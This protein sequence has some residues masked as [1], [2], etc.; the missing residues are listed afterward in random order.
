MSKADIE[1]CFKMI[2]LEQEK[3]IKFS[4]NKPLYWEIRAARMAMQRM[5]AALLGVP[6]EKL[7]EI[8]K[9]S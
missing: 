5:L 2:E 1:L 4:A 8:R 7:E 6:V 9:I 3:M